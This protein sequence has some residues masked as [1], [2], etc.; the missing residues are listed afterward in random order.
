[1]TAFLN[2]EMGEDVYMEQP[3]GCKNASKPDHVC[4]LVKALYG[5]K[6]GPRM[7]N[8]KIDEFL[9][10]L[11]F[12]SSTYDPCI[13]VRYM[14]G[15]ILIVALYVD[16]LL[17]AG[18]E[19]DTIMWMKGELSKRFEMKD[20]GQAKVCLGLEISRVRSEKAVFLS[21]SKYSISILERFGMQDSRPVPTPMVPNSSKSN[22]LDSADPE[23]DA[24]A[25][26]EP[27][28]QAI[29]SLMYLM[30]GTRPDLAYA[31]GKLSRFCEDPQQKHW[32]A[33]KRVFRYIAGSKELGLKF[34]GHAS[35]D[36]VGYSDADWAGDT[37]DRKSTSG[38]VFTLGG[39]PISWGSK[40]QTIVAVST[41]EAEYI[42]MSTASKEAVW[43][44]RLVSDMLL[45]LV[46]TKLH[47]TL[48][49]S[50]NQGAIALAQ[51]ESVNNRNKHID[52]AYH[53]VR[54]VVRTKLVELAYLPST[55]MPA[56]ALTKPLPQPAF[57]KFVM[58][59]ALSKI[60]LHN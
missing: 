24:A 5:T 21:Q 46:S 49:H 33:V 56:D 1:M 18:D 42:S 59:L 10:G 54:E 9:K 27:Y 51:N 22:P 16:D 52:I 3:E 13:Y 20:L 35:L 32:M 53:F 26:D 58:Q 40:K 48:I 60:I 50:D 17:L 7:W 43:L 37:K 45:D 36:L 2:G 15:K 19:P 11:N 55:D 28:R 41:C 14:E 34:D 4:K 38:F 44:R 12:R 31:V 57:A 8:V 23:T 29:G 6:Q 47:P 25:K 30:L 39:G